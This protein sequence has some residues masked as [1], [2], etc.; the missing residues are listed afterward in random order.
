RGNNTINMVFKAS[1]LDSWDIVDSGICLSISKTGFGKA[2]AKAVL[3]DFCKAP[4]DPVCLVKQAFDEEIPAVGK[5]GLYLSQELRAR[6]Y[7]AKYIDIP[8]ALE[9]ASRLLSSLD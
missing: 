3:S 7:A 1:G 5:H 4:I 6:A 8:E 2:D 9:A